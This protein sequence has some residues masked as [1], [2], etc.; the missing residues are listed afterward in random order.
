LA[1]YNNKLYVLGGG[2]SSDADAFHT[3][4]AFDL[5]TRTWEKLTAKPGSF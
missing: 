2:T 3:I 1:L 5:R 4:H